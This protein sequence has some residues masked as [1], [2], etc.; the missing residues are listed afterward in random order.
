MELPEHIFNCGR[1]TNR[2]CDHSSTVGPTACWL[3]FLEKCLNSHPNSVICALWRRGD[4]TPGLPLR[5]GDYSGGRR[6]GRTSPRR[7]FSGT[8]YHYSAKS[9]TGV[10]FCP[11]R[12]RIKS[13]IRQ[14]ARANSCICENSRM[15]R[16]HDN[17]PCAVILRTTFMPDS[18]PFLARGN[19]GRAINWIRDT[20][21]KE[22]AN[23]L[24]SG[25]AKS[26]A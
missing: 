20:S 5:F 9:R 15:V 21:G 7:K 14:W 19:L 3:E 11:N 16:Y 10:V 1:A 22:T 24:K 18:N 25:D 26:Q 4:V 23:L 6:Q 17:Q 12:P 2:P 8:L 13:R